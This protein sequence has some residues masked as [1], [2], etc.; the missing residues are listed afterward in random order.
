MSPFFSICLILSFAIPCNPIL[1]SIH[2][3]YAI[4]I[5]IIVLIFIFVVHFSLFSVFFFSSFVLV[6]FPH[7]SSL[8]IIP[9]GFIFIFNIITT[10]KNNTAIAPTYIIINI[11]ANN[12]IL[13]N[14]NNPV[15]LQNTKIKN[16]KLYIGFFDIIT[17]HA[18]AIAI[19]ANKLNK[20]V[21]NAIFFFFGPWPMP[22]GHWPFYNGLR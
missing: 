8:V 11:I 2:T 6:L 22:K 21:C 1:L 3:L 4:A 17:P 7:A 14:N 10:N 12:S 15:A 20:I 18:A 5:I 9:S 16:I 19:L 13:N